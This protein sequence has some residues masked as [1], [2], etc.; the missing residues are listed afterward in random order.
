H[1]SWDRKLDGRIGAAM[2]SIPAVKGV[3]IGIGFE[4]ARRTGAEVHD[5]IERAPRRPLAGNVRRRSNRAGGLEGGMTTGEPLVVRV[6]MKPI[7][8]LMR[9]LQTVDV[10]TGDAAQAVAE[11]SDVT[12]VPAMGVIAEAML[13]IVLADAFLEKFGGDSLAEVRRNYDGYLSHVAARIAD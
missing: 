13:C 9:P 12:A 5:E 8:T 10:A 11:R 7:S 1:V 6:A 4:A 3:E 2:M